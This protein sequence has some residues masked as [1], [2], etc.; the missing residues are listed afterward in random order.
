MEC[1]CW[2]FEDGTKA[3]EM[4]KLRPDQS[5]IWGRV[6]KKKL[7]R[8]IEIKLS[9]VLFHLLTHYPSG[10]LRCV[11][12]ALLACFVL[13]PWRYTIYI[14]KTCLSLQFV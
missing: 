1:S 9:F 12:L 2:K 10:V 11:M 5:D 3:V 6:Y 13:I 14:C 7:L 8:I 4:A